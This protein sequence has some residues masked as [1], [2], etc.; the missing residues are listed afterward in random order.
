[1]KKKL[2]KPSFIDE[3]KSIRKYWGAIKPTEKIVP[4]KKKYSR[5]KLKKEIIDE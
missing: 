4:N 2:K 5:A 3:Y 1:M